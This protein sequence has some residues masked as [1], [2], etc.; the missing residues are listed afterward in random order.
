MLGHRDR[1]DDIPFFWSAHY[2]KLSIHYTGH[3]EK[4]DATR[5]EGDVDKMDC[6]VSYIVQLSVS[7]IARLR[8]SLGPHARLLRSLAKPDSSNRNTY[9]AAPPGAWPGAEAGP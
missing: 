8:R 1:F 3:V 4:W 5:I 9:E 2:D 7:G 6:A